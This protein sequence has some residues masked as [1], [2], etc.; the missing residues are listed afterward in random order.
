MSYLN[1]FK[2]S[3]YFESNKKS[4][5]NNRVNTTPIYENKLNPTPD[6]YVVL[7]ADGDEGGAA[8]QP[9][10]QNQD[11]TDFNIQ[12][13][14]R[15]DQQS[16]GGPPPMGDPGIGAAPQSNSPEDNQDDMGEMSPEPDPSAEVDTEAKAKDRE[17]FA[18]MTPQEQKMKIVKLKESYKELYER[19]DQIIKKY[20]AISLEFEDYGHIVK[21]SLDILNELKSYISVYLLELFDSNSYIENDI[22]FNRYLIVLNT[23]KNTTDDMCK[24]KKKEIADA[25]RE[26]KLV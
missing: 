11:N 5:Y 4:Y 6:G 15:N 13:S 2:K 18:S 23:I 14:F 24:M 9:A 26:T 16:Q 10:P 12:T 3:S 25:N 1:S 17:L 20:D 21:K 22:M 19:I 8:Q 7:E